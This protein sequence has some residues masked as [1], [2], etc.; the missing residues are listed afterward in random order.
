MPQ[1]SFKGQFPPPQSGSV[2]VI[3]L[4][5]MLVMMVIG[6]TAV[7]TS[8]LEERMAS[9]A[10]NA[11]I[12]FQAAETA[13]QGTAGDVTALIDS[14]AGTPETRTFNIATGVSS[15]ST[16]TYVGPTSLP[17][18]SMG[19]SSSISGHLFDINGVG[20]VTAVNARA[21]HDQGL[22]RVGPG[23]P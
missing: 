2:L 19:S 1:S 11:M 9:N 14:M 17:G 4:L 7:S 20:Q 8:S 18:F 21:N 23:G 15:N 10:Q 5:M 12:S 16:V 6:V 22:V 3:G 13:I